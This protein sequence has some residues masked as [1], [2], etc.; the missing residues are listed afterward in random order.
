[1]T[2]GGRTIRRIVVLRFGGMGDIL[3]ATPAV[4]ALS[5]HFGTTEIDVIVGKGMRDALTGI[6]YLRRIIEFDKGGE[7]IRLK[8]FLPFLQRLRA[9]RYD[10]FVNFHPSLKTITMAIASGAPRVLTF[11]KDQRKQTDTGRMRHAIDDFSKELRPLGIPSVDDRHLDFAI[12]PEAA[13]RVAALLPEEFG[14]AANDTLLVA[15]P[16]A[17]HY[18]NRWPP[19]RFAALL[20]RADDTLPSL[21]LALIGGP[22]DRELAAQV[23]GA[24]TRP[25]RIANLAGRLSIK[26]LGALLARANVVVTGDTGPLHIASAVGAPI[27]ALF[28]PPDPDR[29][30]PQ[31]PGDL[32][33]SHPDLDCIPCHKRTC[34]R[35]DI[36]CMHDLS[37]DLVLAAVRRRL[38][39]ASASRFALA[40]PMQEAQR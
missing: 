5:Q 36:A 35:G 28:G 38:T 8:N 18:V 26:E 11:K 29:T 3:L 27:V 9:E 6:P 30:G 4:R 25:E 21:R 37:V 10:L 7:D 39:A 12:P 22:G 34:R 13:A 1:M 15:N 20:D 16:G 23:V 31:T 32:V 19:D 2:A 14:I 33:V 40:L 24:A 17:S